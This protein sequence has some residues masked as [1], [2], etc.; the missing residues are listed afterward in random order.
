ML[1]FFFKFNKVLSLR[2]DE[3]CIVLR[4]AHSFVQ[5]SHLRP[6]PT[7]WLA[8]MLRMYCSEKL[9]WTQSLFSPWALSWF[10]LKKKKDYLL[11]PY[12]MPSF[13]IFMF[14]LKPLSRSEASNVCFHLYDVLV[15]H[16][17]QPWISNLQ[18]CLQDHFSF[19]HKT[20]GIQYIGLS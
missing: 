10:P 12:Q 13:N 15:S 4:W 17:L 1:S 3:S 16:S 9:L 8:E 18:V 5:V 14:Y 6:P 11:R 19:L 7:I 20:A 2:S